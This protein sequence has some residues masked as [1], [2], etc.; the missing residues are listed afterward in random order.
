MSKF[1]KP[2]VLKGVEQIQSVKKYVNCKVIV[3]GNIV[4]ITRYQYGYTKGLQGTNKTGRKGIEGKTAEEQAKTQIENRSKTLQ[5]ARQHIRRLA[6]ANPQLDKFFTLTFKDNIKDIKTANTE[7]DKFIKRLN[8]YSTKNG[9]KKVQYIAVVEFQKRGAV[10][11]HLLC[12]LPFISAKT[13]E[14]IWQNGFIKINKI[15]KVDNIGAYITKYMSKDNHDIRLIG[16]RCYFTSQ[17]LNEPIEITDSNEIAKLLKGQKI[18][19]RYTSTFESEYFGKIS[20][21]QLVLHS[22]AKT[23]YLR[24]QLK[25]KPKKY[26]QISFDYATL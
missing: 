9:L 19:R 20:Y 15:D 18:I 21:T 10:H 16:K 24:K 5:R 6:N 13:L 14:S 17:G 12:D 25:P 4:E 11:Y 2:L 22:N 23:G 7:F 1:I 26:E 8:Y 3:S